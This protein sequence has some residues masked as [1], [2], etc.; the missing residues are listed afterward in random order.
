MGALAHL[1]SAT[2]GV[3]S[4]IAYFNRGEHHLHGTTYLFTYTT[5]YATWTIALHLLGTSLSSAAAQVTA[6]LLS[7]FAGLYLSLLI[8]RSFLH[9]L[10]KFPGP[11]GARISKFFL[12][13]RIKDR[14]AFRTIHQLH[15]EY[16]DFVR[17]GPS[18][19]SVSKCGKGTWYDLTL[20]SVSLQTTRSRTEHDQRRRLWSAGFS[21]KALRGY[22]T[23]M[24]KYRRKL[25]SQ[26]EAFGSQ[27]VDVSKWFNL[28]TYD[29]MDDLAFGRP[30]G[31][32]DASEQHWAIKLLIEGLEPH[33]WLLPVWFLRV[34]QAIPGMMDN[35]FKALAYS[36][37]MVEK[38]MTEKPDIP[39]IM[40]TLLEPLKGRKATK[41]DLNSLHG[42]SQLVIIAGSD[43][44]AT[45]L[46]CAVLELARNPDQQRKLRKELGLYMRDRTKDVANQDIVKCDHL[47]GVIYEALRL[48]P[49]LPT[50]IERKTPPEGMEIGGQHI[51]G[52]MTVW[53][54][55]FVTGR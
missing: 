52:S 3:I 46:T 24:L 55:P 35:W 20:P 32:L 40:S 2:A 11:F 50:A 4:H 26:I 39:D 38:R 7:Y 43:T 28:Y 6:Y 21:D 16:G 9:P 23:R 47:N 53:C 30:F 49:P 10:N 12:S 34:A 19:L 51:P 45:A 41:R 36:H 5:I 42:D 48:Y 15:E 29:T 44:T 13:T 27:P 17:M 8:Y 1:L 22:E 25:L 37:Q 54:S 14:A 31:I 33:S 18:D